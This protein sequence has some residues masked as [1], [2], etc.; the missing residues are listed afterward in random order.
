MN[1]TLVDQHMRHYLTKLTVSDSPMN[2]YSVILLILSTLSG[3]ANL[4]WANNLKPDELIYDNRSSSASPVTAIDYKSYGSDQ[5]GF[6][7]INASEESLKADELFPIKPHTESDIERIHT[8]NHR[9]RLGQVLVFTADIDPR[10]SGF[11]K[12]AKNKPLSI[13]GRF[14]PNANS[15]MAQGVTSGVVSGATLG[16]MTVNSINHQVASA[17]LKLS[18]AGSNAVMGGQMALG[19]IGGLIAGGIHA[20]MAESALNGIIAGKNFGERMDV[21]TTT[22]AHLLPNL[23]SLGPYGWLVKNSAP[24]VI[25][26]GVIKRYFMKLGQKTLDYKNECYIITAVGVFRGKEYENKYPNTLGWSYSISNMALIY[27][28]SDDIS[29]PEK[30]FRAIKRE[31]SG[32]NIF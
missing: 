11:L 12:D 20:S 4:D 2:K 29:N 14:E 31:T 8:H 28:S 24:V 32:K 27:L 22:A 16:V 13:S 1:F 30:L 25:A 21:T 18:D 6:V 3:C 10:T 15:A 17:G 7:G 19:L 5:I 9:W 26:P 23:N